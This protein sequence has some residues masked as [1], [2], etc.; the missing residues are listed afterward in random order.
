MLSALLTM[1]LSFQRILHMYISSALTAHISHFSVG[2]SY[3]LNTIIMYQ[4]VSCATGSDY[5]A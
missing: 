3:M 5:L 1:M 2:N 4:N